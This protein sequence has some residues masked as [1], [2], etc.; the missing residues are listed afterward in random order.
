MLRNKKCSLKFY[1]NTLKK[2]AKTGKIP[3]YVKLVYNGKKV[4]TRLPEDYDLSEKDL[5][6]W[7]N[8]LMRLRIP[9]SDTNDFIS[10]I[11]ANWSKYKALN[12]HTPKDSLPKIINMIFDRD[13]PNHDIELLPFAE[14]FLNKNIK[15]SNRIKEGTKVNY[16]KSLTH[17]TNFLKKNNLSKISL[18]DFKHV[19]ASD[20]Q[21]YMMDEVGNL[22]VS[23]TAIIKNLKPIFTEA[24]NQELIVKNPF[25][26]LKLTYRSTGKTPN[27][28]LSQIKMILD[29][30]EIA[31]DRKLRYYRDLFIFGCFTGLSVSNIMK[32]SSNFVFPIYKNRL[33]LDTSRVKT[34][35]LIV[36]IIPKYAQCIIDKYRNGCSNG[37]IFPKFCDGTFNKALKVIGAHAKINIKLTTKISRTT[38]TQIVV[39][40]GQFDVIYKR[41]FLGWSNVSDI[42]SVYT[43]LVDD[44][45]LRNTERL[46][47]LLER[48]LGESLKSIM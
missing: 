17:L 25:K 40:A 13:T 2:K 7:D 27:I 16:Q 24:I 47:E 39:N 18:T 5:L 44:I 6:K 30:K 22:P 15:L 29:S 43:E 3:I 21:L 41:A 1:P 46:E 19:H 14:T 11:Q 48:E 28:T 8:E 10:T 36:Q 23:T 33:K 9:E 32:L 26:N 20:F 12:G 45:I 34:D 4:E 31:N 42:Q 35:E 38:C 37:L